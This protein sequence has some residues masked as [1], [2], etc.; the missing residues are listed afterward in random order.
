MVLNF[1]SGEFSGGHK[2]N[3][4]T[5][6]NYKNNKSRFS[7]YDRKKCLDSFNYAIRTG[8][9]MAF[10]YASYYSWVYG[11][12]KL[13]YYSFIMAL[14]YDNYNGYKITHGILENYYHKHWEDSTN[15]SSIFI[16]FQHYIL[17]KACQKGFDVK[18]FSHEPYYNDLFD[19]NGKIRHPDFFLEKM[20]QGD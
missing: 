18:S 2:E 5:K 14:N 8:D 20:K 13:F 9:S 15:V 10:D 12:E 11:D 4:S 19:H 1:N 17:A 16:N 6:K 7:Y 3:D